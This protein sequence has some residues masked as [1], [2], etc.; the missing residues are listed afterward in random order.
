LPGTPFNQLP[1]AVAFGPED[2]RLMDSHWDEAVEWARRHVS[3]Q[4]VIPPPPK[5]HL[6]PLGRYVA[7]ML[8]NM[9]V[10][11]VGGKAFS[12]FRRREWEIPGWLGSAEALRQAK[13]MLRMGKVPAWTA[14]ALRNRPDATVVHIVR[15]PA[16]YLHAWR[17]RWAGSRDL[18]QVASANRQRLMN[19]ARIH[20]RWAERIGDVTHIPA[21][22]A[23]LWF[24]RYATETIHDA[25]TESGR[26]ELVKD[27]AMVIDPIGTS[28]RLYFACGL[29]WEEGLERYLAHKAE[30]WKRHTVRHSELLDEEMEKAIARVMA[31]SPMERWWDG[32]EVVSLFTYVFR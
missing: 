7:G 16:A 20:P 2:A 22:E 28:R 15:H 17:G 10:R 21:L 12:I 11:Q 27:E 1:D 24:W 30:H 14:W 32:L 19:V 23:E 4:D 5:E 26:Y 6:R 25:G 8:G 13:L 3:A 29:P 9:R 31:G 18:D